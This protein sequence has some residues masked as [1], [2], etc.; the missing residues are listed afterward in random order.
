MNNTV[1]AFGLRLKIQTARSLNSGS[2]AHDPE[3]QNFRFFIFQKELI[4]A[5]T[6]E[7]K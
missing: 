4:I 3:F 2:G 1:A 5:L 6:S 7:L